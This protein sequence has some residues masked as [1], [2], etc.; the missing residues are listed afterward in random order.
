MKENGVGTDAD[1]ASLTELTR[2][3]QRLKGLWRLATRH[4]LGDDARCRAILC[5]AASSMDMDL[6]VL[7]EFSPAGYRARFTHDSLGVLAEGTVVPSREVLCRHVQESAEPLFLDDLDRRPDLAGSSLAHQLGM[8]VYGGIPVWIGEQVGGVLAFLRRTPLPEAFHEADIAYM[9]LVAGWLGHHLSQARQRQQLE[10]HALTDVLTGLLNRRAAESRLHEEL[11]R[12]RRHNEGFA[13]ALVDIDHFKRVNDRY[14][15]A[16]GDQVLQ[17]VAARLESALRDEDW[18]ARWGG[19]EFLVFL[20]NVDQDEAAYVMQRLVGV[21]KATPIP[22]EAGEVRLTLSAGIGFPGREDADFHA[23]VDLADACLYQAK[24]NGRD[25]VEFR[26]GA[27]ARWPA[28]VIKRAL[29][30]SRLRM[31]SQV[32]V[33]LETGAVVADESLARVEMPDGSLV[34]AGEF[35]EVAEGLGLMSE[36]DR[37][38]TRQ[39]MARCTSKLGAGLAGPDFAHFVN[40][41][42]QFLARRDLVEEM[43]ANAQNYCQACGITLGPVKPIVFEITERQFLSNLD[44]LEAD[45]KPLLDFGFRLAL[46]DFGSGYSSFLY[47][48]RLPI[49]FLKIEGWMVANMKKERKIAAIV[50]SLAGFARREGIVSV[51]ECIEDADTARILREM[52]V[53]LG[54]G[55]HFGRPVL[56]ESQD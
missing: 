21:V 3:S 53:H 26:D 35:V 15:H 52:G 7:G 8:R 4:D 1:P 16:V 49:S 54:Q 40:L 11:A 14:G 18:L 46:D 33:D 27:G 45:L 38:V 13:L 29:R 37:Y 9:E 42:P 47:L 10:R 50:E 28:Q 56:E 24:S 32:I 23:A 44:S 5:E 25:R 19:E 55:W 12:T 30:D 22:T 31:A 2:Q 17:G 48:A 20:R 34:T 41:S 36:I 43:L 6:A 51:A 39:A